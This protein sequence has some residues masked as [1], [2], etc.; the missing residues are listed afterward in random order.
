VA[1]LFEGCYGAFDACFDGRNQF[2]QVMF[3][4]AVLE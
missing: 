1:L 4:P 3:V 2:K